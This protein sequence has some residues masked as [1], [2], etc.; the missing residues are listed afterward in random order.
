MLLSNMDR[1]HFTKMHGAGNDY[2]YINCIEN[3]PRNLASLSREMS[4]RHKGVGG[5][6]II[7]I[8]PSSEADFKMRIFNADGSEARMCGNGS[9]CVAKYVYDNRLTDKLHLTLET[10]SGVK[11][12]Y[13]KPGSDNKVESVTVDMGIPSLACKDIPVKVKTETFIDQEITVVDSNKIRLTAVSMGNPHAVITIPSS[14]DTYNVEILGPL[15]ENHELFPDRAN[16]EFVEIIDRKTLKARVWERGSGETLACGTGAC[17]TVVACATLGL[18]DRKVTVS[19]PGGNLDIEWNEQDGHVYMTG[20][21]V[22]VF[23]GVYYI[24]GESVNHV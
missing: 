11:H 12:L 17:A 20:P 14:V 7:L 16:V 19:L 13:L 10:L 9:R 23:T 21:A 6:G 1:I 8:L 4:D 15:I 3:C 5:D 2:V 18:T 22:T 24:K